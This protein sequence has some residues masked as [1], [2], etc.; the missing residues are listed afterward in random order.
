[1]HLA[2]GEVAQKVLSGQLTQI[3]FNLEGIAD[4]VA[5]ADLAAQGLARQQAAGL[6][7]NW[8][9]VGLT[10]AELNTIRSDPSL[11]QRTTFYRKG[12]PVPSPF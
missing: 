5:S 2:V 3:H 9:A 12:H 4:P 7:I 1:M 10:N 11:L 6:P 8:T